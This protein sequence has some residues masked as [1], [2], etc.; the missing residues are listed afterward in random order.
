MACL[1]TKENDCTEGFDGLNE[2]HNKSGDFFTYLLVISTPLFFAG[3]FHAAKIAITLASPMSVLFWR[4]SLALVVLLPF[5]LRQ[6]REKRILH[7]KDLPLFLATGILGILL[8]HLLVFIALQHTSAV[9]TAVIGSFAPLLTSVAAAIWA[10][11]TLGLKRLGTL[12]LALFGVL[13]TLSKGD[14][15]TFV[16]MQF[17]RGDVIMLISVVFLTA[18]NVV[19]KAV[20]KHYTALTALFY[21]TLVAIL[22]ATPFYLLERPWTTFNWTS[23]PLWG[24]LF[25]M[26]AGATAM[27]YLFFQIGIKRLGV[28]RTVPFLN[29]TPIFSIIISIFLNGSASISSVQVLSSLIIVLGVYLNSRL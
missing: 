23:W 6:P 24:S 2:Q 9:N 29:L 26:A 7:K 19:S 22:V 28:S 17:N 1:G 25:Y 12:L 21:A 4:F 20:L 18:Y 5:M 10:K 16:E 8:Y 13:L 27:G 3:A 15:N 11:E 14:L